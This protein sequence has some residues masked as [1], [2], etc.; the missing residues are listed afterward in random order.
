VLKRRDRGTRVTTCSSNN[1]EN[2]DFAP[3][4]HIRSRPQTLVAQ[5]ERRYLYTAELPESGEGEAG[6]WPVG[7]VAVGEEVSR[8]R[9]GEQGQ[10]R[11]G[12]IEF[13]KYKKILFYNTKNYSSLYFP[14]FATKIYKTRYFDICEFQRVGRM[15]EGGRVKEQ[16]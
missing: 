4:S 3:I 14:L 13:G 15:N 6:A 16:Q 9:G 2:K 12:C 11:Q 10:E 7:E 5:N 1:Q 8:E